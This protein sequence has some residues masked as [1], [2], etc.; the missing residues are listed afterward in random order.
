MV[1]FRG[2]AGTGRIVACAFALM[3]S[4]APAFAQSQQ[5]PARFFRIQDV[6][7]KISAGKTL[8]ADEPI[9]LATRGDDIMS[10]VPL[11]GSLPQIG[12]EPFGL[13]GFRAPEGHS[14]ASG[15]RFQARWQARKT[16]SR[17]AAPIRRIARRQPN[18]SSP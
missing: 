1:R 5:G 17:S 15:A 16:S 13:F 14:G 8:G 9:R 6:L 11:R 7:N 2:A 10:D 3:I 12:E 4:A 18:T